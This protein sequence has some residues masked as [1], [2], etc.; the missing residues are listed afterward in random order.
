MQIV[1]GVIAAL[2]LIFAYFQARTIIPRVIS[3]IGPGKRHLSFEEDELPKDEVRREMI[4]PVLEKMQAAGF[5]TLGVMVEKQPL[6]AGV[7]RELALANRDQ[8]VFASI[9]F[10]RNK[11]SYFLYTPFTDGKVVITA[12]NSFRAFRRDDFVTDV[13]PSGELEE[14][15]EVHGNQVRHF[16]DKGSEPYTEYTRESLIK[17]TLQFYTS[18]YPR[19]QLRTA[20]MFNI[21]FLIICLL[22]VVVLVRAAI[23]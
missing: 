10:R 1:Y 23:G 22:L 11:L 2:L 19:Q 7:T 15:L 4:K 9:G 21:F 6:W 20:A 17:A 12:F 5:S 14:M 8:A 16:T 13:V 3:F 18:P